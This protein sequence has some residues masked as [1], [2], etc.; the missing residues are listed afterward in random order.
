[1]YVR[2][3]IIYSLH[4]CAVKPTDTTYL[5]RSWCIGQNFQ[6]IIGRMTGWF[7]E[8]INLVTINPS[9]SFLCG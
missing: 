2:Q 1:M 3:K 5:Y 6:T 8:D 4:P 9:G 7:K